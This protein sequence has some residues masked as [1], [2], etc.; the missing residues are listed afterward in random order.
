MSEINQED[1]MRALARQLSCPSGEHG[2]KT[3][4]MMAE[5]NSNMI[6]CTIDALQLRNYESV[7]ELGPGGG[8]HLDNLMNRS[9]EIKYMGVDTS[10]LMIT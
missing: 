5:N 9:T 4:G 1:Q 3:A 10:E 8:S 2:I 7:L 6:L